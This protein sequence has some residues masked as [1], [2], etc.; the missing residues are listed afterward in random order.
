MQPIMNFPVLLLAALIPMVMGFIY[1]NP[2]VF[3]N[4]W[5]Q[6]C[7]LTEEKMK[8]A[9]MPL[10]FAL[11]YLFSFFL[12]MAMGVMLVIHQN[13]I[14]SIFANDPGMKDPN[15]PVYLYVQDFMANYGSN[16][17]TF[18]HGAV[19]G[20]LASLFIVLP[21]LGTCA[22]FERKN[23]KYIAINVGYWLITM[24]LMGGVICQYS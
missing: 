3:G 15:S 18:K 5:M 22:L 21:V 8:G 19:H 4:A 10:V 16:F 20:V 24:A 1:Y 17:R 6:S 9:N 11:S 13:H 12:A 7:G 2:K 23:F 14:Y